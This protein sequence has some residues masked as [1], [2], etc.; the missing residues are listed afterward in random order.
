MTTATQ[1]KPEMAELKGFLYMHWDSRGGTTMVVA[2]NREEADRRYVKEVFMYDNETIRN[3]PLGLIDEDFGSTVTLHFRKGANLN[4]D[5]EWKAD[6]KKGY[7]LC[8]GQIAS[9]PPTDDDEDEWSDEANDARNA[10]I[11]KGHIELEYVAPGDEPVIFKDGWYN[12]RWDDDA[13]SFVVHDLRIIRH[14]SN[15]EGSDE[16]E[17][18]FVFSDGFRCYTSEKQCITIAPDGSVAAETYKSGSDEF[19]GVR[20]DQGPMPEDPQPDDFDDEL[21]KDWLKVMGAGASIDREKGFV[22]LSDDGK[23]EVEKH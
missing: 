23:L 11:D 8:K 18:I 10:E 16:F 1:N 17:N 4:G 13:F 20:L 3:M 12:P 2:P 19:H 6:N 5:L 7:V 9:W 15:L 14:V 21:M 22:S